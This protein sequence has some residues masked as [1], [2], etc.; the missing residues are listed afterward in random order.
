MLA[1]FVDFLSTNEAL[2]YLSIRQMIII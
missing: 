1:D 2:K